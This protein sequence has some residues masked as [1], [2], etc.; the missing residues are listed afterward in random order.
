MFTTVNS[1]CFSC[2]FFN[3][4]PYYLSKKNSKLDY[5]DNRDRDASKQGRLSHH[6]EIEENT[7]GSLDGAHLSASEREECILK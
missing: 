6:A 2:F 3:N 1:L 5:E 7:R 4:I